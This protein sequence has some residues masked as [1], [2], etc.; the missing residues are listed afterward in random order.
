M[1]TVVDKEMER[2]MKM[3]N[4]KGILVFVINIL[5]ICSLTNLFVIENYSAMGATIYDDESNTVG[6]WNRTKYY[7]HHTTHEGITAINR[8]DTILVLNGYYGGLH[9]DNMIITKDL[10]LSGKNK[11][12]IYINGGGNGY[13]VH[14]YG[15]IGNKIYVYLSNFTIRNAIGDGY[16]CIAFSYIAN[17]KIIDNKILNS[18]EGK[19]ISDLGSV[20]RERFSYG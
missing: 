13:T 12:T 1:D 10:T 6:P 14:A 5:M 3:V 7:L 15:A 16:D 2:D 8:G 17:G 20:K 4:A 18:Q 19:G 11:D 9:I